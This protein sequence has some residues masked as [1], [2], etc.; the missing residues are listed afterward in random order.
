MDLMATVSIAR[1]E[2]ELV[3]TRGHLFALGALSLALAVLSFFVGLQLGRTDAP[4]ATA[5]AVDPLV[6]E[7]V[8]GGDL[9]VLLARVEA[10]SRPHA[11]LT[12]PEKLE[13]SD[14]IPPPVDPSA[15]VDP[16]VAA[17]VAPPV[18]PFPD[19]AT[20]RVGEAMVAGV[21]RA[22]APVEQQIPAGKWAVQVA[23]RPDE[24]DA[25]VLVDTLRAAG[26]QAY[27]VPALV[28]GQ[29]LWRVRVGGYN[30]KEGATAAL[31]EVSARAGTTDA[32]VTQAP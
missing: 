6:R 11:E 26:L 4:I 3:L 22:P 8:R 16:A 13:E 32:V 21:V 28:D 9:E 18:D 27:R 10:A 15:P 29:A 19:D 30:S 23:S 7:E 1:P 25:S 31:G 14:L 5:P 17:V 2:R 24:A 20:P 12:F